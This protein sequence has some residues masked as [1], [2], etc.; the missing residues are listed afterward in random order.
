VIGIDPVLDLPLNEGSG[1]T[2]YDRS[3]YNHHGTIYNAVWQ[4][5]WRDSVLYFDGTS[6]YVDCGISPDFNLRELTM[7]LWIK[8]PDSMGQT[9]RN[10][11]S[12]TGADRDFGFWLYS[13]D[14]VKVTGLHQSSARFGS[15]VA[16]L[17][18]PF[19]PNTWH[20]VV[21]VIYTTGLQKAYADG[22]LVGSYQGTAG[23][24]NN[25]YPLLIG[26]SDNYWKGLIGQ[27]QLFRKALADAQ[28]QV[29]ANLFRGEL[30]KPP[31]L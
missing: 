12:K 19:E 6:A 11:M 8:T 26:K 15:W 22:Q 7:A 29:L 1:T 28:I 20:H 25:S 18:T 31:S 3:G 27:A 4:K 17:P 2:V 10:I 23:Y 5:I 24:A 21:M 30:R 13:S 9:W 14:K 16:S